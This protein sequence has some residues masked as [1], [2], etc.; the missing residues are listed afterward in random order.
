MIVAPSV[1]SVVDRDEAHWKVA[2]RPSRI[3]VDLDQIAAN[4]TF[5]RRLVS[6]GTNVMAVVKADGYGHGAIMAAN[7][8]LDAGATQLAIATVDEGAVLRAAGISAPLLV[9]GPIEPSELPSALANRLTL[10]ISDQNFI[11]A[12]ARA[13]RGHGPDRRVPVHIKI[14]SGMRR[15]GALPEDVVPIFEQISTYPELQ[16]MGTYSH[17]ADADGAS[18]QFS[19]EQAQRFNA[20]VRLVRASGFS[21][22]AVHLSNSAATLRWREYDHDLVRIGICLYGLSPSPEMTL[23]EGLAPALRLQCRLAR[24]T[25]LAPGDCV[26][27]GCA[28]IASSTERVG[29]VP[30]GYA[31]GYRRGLSSRGVMTINGIES[32]V[33][34]RICMDQCVISLPKSSGA[35]I[36]TV[37]NVISNVSDQPNSVASIA[38]QLGTIDYEVVTGLSRRIPRLYIKRRQ[39]VARQDLQTVSLLDVP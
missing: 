5:F 8:A 18:D 31:D 13:A 1:N 30:I 10:T 37:V 12:V 32:E 4:V 34:G 11:A 7:A 27:Y 39:V 17:F 33:R 22:G 36:N 3:I 35:H 15:F 28:Y 20:C 16:V 21:T 2:G 24:V 26:S 25:T 9:L 6:P 23:P 19:R 29:L 38:K 14:D